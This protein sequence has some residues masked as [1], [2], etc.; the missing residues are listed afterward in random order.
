MNNTRQQGRPAPAPGAAPGPAAPGGNKPIHTIRM[1]FVKA[2]IW[3]NVV[4]DT[5]R[6]Y[7]V[8]LSRFYKDGDQWKSTESFGRDELLVVAKVADHAHTWICDQQ[9]QSTA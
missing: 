7:N 4:N 5:T 8:S 1:G 3:E 9:T 6:Y 2:A